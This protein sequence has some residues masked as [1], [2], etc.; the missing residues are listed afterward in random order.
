[1]RKAL[2]NMEFAVTAAPLLML[3]VARHVT[4]DMVQQVAKP[5]SNAL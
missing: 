3:R 2:G 1:M 5:H 4:L